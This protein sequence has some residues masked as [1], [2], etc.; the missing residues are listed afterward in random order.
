MR[1]LLSAGFRRMFKNWVFWLGVFSAAAL[2]VFRLITWYRMGT[3]EDTFLW[4]GL[5]CGFF[6]AAF[7]SLFLGAEFSGGAIRNEI[8]VGH[9][10][11]AVYLSRFIVCTAAGWLMYLSYILVQ[12]FV[13]V[14]RMETYKTKIDFIL[15]CT[16]CTFLLITAFTAIFTMIAMLTQNRAAAAVSCLLLTI[17]L[18]AAGSSIQ[19]RLLVPEKVLSYSINADGERYPVY[20]RN[21]RYVSGPMRSFLI[22]LQDFLP[23]GQAVQLSD[24]DATNPA[25]AVLPMHP[26]LMEL[27][28]MILT[29][30]VTGIGM[31]L[32]HRKN[33]K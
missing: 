27:Y 6:A 19:E 9:E 22:F 16:F 11:K 2:S 14:P 28:S 29:A 4:Y 32:F 31:H 10:R 25:V 21:S 23:G 12:L 30:A 3:I 5:L 8:V 18:L 17:L 26:A 24:G 7:C 13:Y 1:N 33:L 15:L 20:S